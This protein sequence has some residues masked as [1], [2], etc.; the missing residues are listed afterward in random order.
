VRNFVWRGAVTVEREWLNKQGLYLRKTD[1]ADEEGTKHNITTTRR[2][3]NHSTWFVEAV[4]IPNRYAA[5]NRKRKYCELHPYV[6]VCASVSPDVAWQMDP[7]EFYSWTSFRCPRQSRY[8]W[9]T[10]TPSTGL[11]FTCSQRTTFCDVTLSAITNSRPN[12]G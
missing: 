3:Q 11:N 10:S 2:H 4:V 1:V 12:C 8:A 7:Q 5:L 9:V 6:L